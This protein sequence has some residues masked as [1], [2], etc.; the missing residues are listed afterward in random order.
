MVVRVKILV[1]TD[2]GKNIES[3]AIL[4]S[5]YESDVCEI[6]LPRKVAKKIGILLKKGVMENYGTAGP[7][8]RVKRIPN[9]VRVYLVTED[10]KVGP[11]TADAIIL[12]SDE[13]LLNDKLIDEFGV[14]LEK[15]GEGLWRFKDDPVSTI[16]KSVKAQKW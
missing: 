16:R 8:I 6:A 13:I 3:S 7:S 12:G 5:G 1:E 10:R 4:N 14:V 15:V 2:K 11:V 9:A